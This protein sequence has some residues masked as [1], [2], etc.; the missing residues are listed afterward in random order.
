MD[1]SVENNPD[2]WLASFPRPRAIVNK[3][4]RGGAVIFGAPELSGATR[5]SAVACSRIGAGLVTVLADKMI[6]IFKASLPADIMVRSGSL[7]ALKT[8]NVLLGGPG[9]ISASHHSQLLEN[10]HGAKR[11]FDASAIPEEMDWAYLDD[12]CVL[13]PHQGEFRSIFPWVDSEPCR[14]AVQA[15]KSCAG[16]I[17]LKGPLTVIAHP[18]GRIVLNN[19]PNPYLAKAGTGDV[20]AGF[21]AGLLAQGMPAFEGACAAVW[22]HSRAGDMLG[23]GLTAADLEFTIPEIYRDLEIG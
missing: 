5:L 14:S 2:I 21:I 6:D 8:T 17:V 12:N 7:E 20:L 18:D 19:E 23:P 13:T 1:V 22:I 9:G 16:I 3:H 10:L 4:D 15:A 11:V